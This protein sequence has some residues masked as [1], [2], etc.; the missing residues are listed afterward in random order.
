MNM[1]ACGVTILVN[2]VGECEQE[3]KP[4]APRLDSLRGESI[5]FI[6]TGKPKVEHFLDRIEEMLHRDYPGLQI[7]TVRKDFTSGLPIAHEF[8]GKVHAV[9]SAWGD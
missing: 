7:R 3:E 9:I 2:P 1:R 8:E 5:G 6:H 4:L